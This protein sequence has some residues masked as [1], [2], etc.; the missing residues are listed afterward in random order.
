MKALLTPTLGQ[1]SQLA[2]HGNVIPV[3][4]EFVADGETPVSA[5]K[6]LDPPQAGYSFLF[7]STEKNDVS[8]RFSF[9]GIDPRIV[10]KTYG[11]ELQIV[12]LG[13]ERRVEITGD[14]LDQLRKLMARYQFVSRPE[15]PRFSGGAVGF[16]GY[17]AIHFFEPKVP[18]GERDELQLPEMVFMIT[19]SLLIFDH[20]L[21]TLK[22]VANAFLDD[23]PLE[24]VYARA[25]DSIHGIM[26][27]LARPADLPLA[28][29]ADPETQA[30]HSNFHPDEF[31]RAV[32]RAKEYIR[33]GDIFQVVLSQRF[34][35][36][37]SGDPL[38]FYRCLRFINPSPYMF[39]LKLGADF[40]LVGSSPEMHVRLIGDAVEI[41]PLA[42]TRPRG[43]TFT[44]DEKNATELLADPKERAEH[45]MLVDLARNDVGRVSDFGT[46]RVTELME[47]E[48]Y[49]HVMHI[50]SNVTG[51]LRTGCTGFDLVRAT[52]PAGTVSGAPKIRAM[53]I[54]SELEK[55]RR[56]CYAGAIGYFGFDGHVDSCIA[57]RCAVL[58]N[59][60]A[61]FQAG[62]GIV[63]DSNPHAEYEETVNKA[64]AMAKALLMA[65]QIRPPRGG[66]REYNAS[67][68][69]D[70]ELRELTLR[71]MRGENLSR[72]EAANFLGCLLN[73]IATDAQIAAALTSLALKG[74]TFDELAGIAEAMR[75]RALPLR[76]RHARF[77]DTAG[78][79]S[80]A[81]KTFNISTAAAFVIAGAGLPVAKHGS[82]A[83][84]SRCGSADVLEALGVNTT[85]PPE[86]VERC[87]NEH[88]ICFMFAPLF[89]A[90][91][92]R[93][94][95]VR[96]ELGMHTT[97]NLLG[98]LTNPA[99]PPFQI[100]GVRHLS[101]LE[102]VASALAG[103]GVEKAW[104][105]HGAD[106]LDEITIADKT[107]V[108]ACSSTG[109]VETFTLSPEDFGL[110]RQHFDG[111][112]G[113]GPQENAQ[114]IRAILRGVKTHPVAVARDLV[115]INAAAALHLAGVAPDLR[116]AA[117]LA[118]ESID[119][120]RTASK[121]DVLVRET[122][123][124]L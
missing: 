81:A 4:T 65:K 71:L 118:R 76:S 11:H 21:R 12:E 110:K 67:E 104:V 7:E 27:Q 32:E 113:K 14:P 38:D 41:R 82:R 91:M 46:V 44:Q 83:A 34:E 99:R 54:I 86:I 22:I 61:Y 112:R 42:G 51:R 68:I 106:G 16:L 17:E 123:R 120:G 10:I 48:R 85:A 62:A 64:R 33:A 70:F 3:F 96:R 13:V 25:T 35:S 2:K 40:A 75:N 28:P 19:T 31:K 100:L 114:L 45:I 89:H 102:R 58:K 15:L 72:V 88:E 49:S 117:S 97:F 92:A 30:A 6:K 55:T 108:A 20:R 74:E 107:H 111:F 60:K 101:L 80:S 36:D 8:G 77:I 84:T 47:I 116:C 94:A 109:E 43:A 50:V 121:L 73:P 1:F 122:N 24:E 66:K 29:P 23:G 90:A 59:G 105:V 103:L 53:Q 39:C 9:V 87:L 52:F 124:G 93:V 56:G 5:F 95:H 69:G 63:A 119:S 26:R 115:I 79:G 78:T 57:L 98:P 37:F 18:I